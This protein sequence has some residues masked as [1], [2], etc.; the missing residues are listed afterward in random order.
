VDD[1][2][3]GQTDEEYVGDPITCG[4]GACEAV[5]VTIC[6]G[7]VVLD[8]CTPGAKPAETDGTCDGVDDDCSGEADED[9]CDVADPCTEAD[10][11]AGLVCQGSALDCSDGLS[12]TAD[13]CAG[14]A[15][16]NVI[17]AGSCLVDETCHADLEAAAGNECSL[18]DVDSSQTVFTPVAD[19]LPCEVVNTCVSGVCGAPA[20]DDG[21]WNGDETDQDCGGSCDPCPPLSLCADG[22][23]CEDGV[24]TDDI[25]QEPTCA[26]GVSNGD[27]TDEDCGGTCPSGCADGAA[28]LVVGDCES[29]VCT[30]DVCQVAS[31][32]DGV[33][34][35]TETAQDCGGG[36]C[37]VCLSGQ[38]CLLDGDCLTGSCGATVTNQ[39][40]AVNDLSCM[41]WSVVD[42]IFANYNCTNCHGGSGGLSLTSYGGVM[43]P[44]N[45]GV[46][47]VA[48][49]AASSNLYL[50]LLDSP[51][52]KKQMPRNGPNYLTPEELLVVEAW[53]DLGATELC[54]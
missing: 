39:C 16:V 48:G 26:D 25:C 30:G 52:F 15:C 42:V 7:G 9:A 20:C 11:C 5:G 33:Q 51:P 23:D 19:G 3:D 18:C 22:S 24:C 28:C 35:G 41:S 43:T 34:N 12:C 45:N 10:A 50:K 44:A 27:E 1:D 8:D 53:I 37:P 14:G 38:G 36:D 32:E 54:P 13:S 40:D 21:F 29:G 31:C 2:C 46:A 4:V 6:Q 47:V 17:N 49:D